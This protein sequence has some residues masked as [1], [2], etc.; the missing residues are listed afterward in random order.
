MS[1]SCCRRSDDYL[2]VDRLSSRRRAAVVLSVGAY[3]APRTMGYVNVTLERDE[4][5]AR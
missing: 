1:G 3:G 4:E 5:L 2:T